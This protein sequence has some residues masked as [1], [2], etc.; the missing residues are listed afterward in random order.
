MSLSLY[1]PATRS[2][3]IDLIYKTTGAD[4]TKY[5]LMDVVADI[6]LAVDKFFEIAVK[7]SGTWQLDDSNQTDYP[8]L[9]TSLISGRRYYSFTQDSAGNLILDIYRVMA[10]NPNGVF[11]DLQPVDQQAP[12]YQSMGMVDGQNLTGQPTK[13]DK[14]ANGI[15]LDAIPNYN[16]T[17]G[18]KIF[19]N[20]EALRFSIPTVN[21]ADSTKP[22][23]IGTLH[24]YFVLRPS[25]FYALRKGLQNANALG[26]EL[27][28]YEGNENAGITGSIGEAYSKRPKDERTQIKTIYRSSR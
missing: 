20:R 14:T 18:L 9:T 24:E 17:N 28:K 19:I 11:Y 12:N 13:Y 26:A 16:Y 7:S 23:F 27:M 3:I 25:Y 4:T 21:V 1:Q 10:A 2:G 22:G 6:N 8:I 15:F 5:P